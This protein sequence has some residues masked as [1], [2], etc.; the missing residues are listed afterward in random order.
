ML[1]SS[2][3]RYDG[4]LMEKS[5][6][7]C[8][9]SRQSSMLGILDIALYRMSNN[10]LSE[11]ATDEFTGWLIEQQ[12]NGLLASF[13][14]TQM[15]TVHAC[16][17]KLLESALRIGDANFLELLID[18]GIDNSPLK[19]VYGGRNL[20]RA[21]SRD[22]M[23]IV[24]IL[25]KNGADVNMPPRQYLDPA[26]QVATR[27][28]HAQIVQ[29]LLKAGANVNAVSTPSHCF[30]D[31]NT[32]LSEAADIEIIELVRILLT[33]GANIDIYTTRWRLSTIDNDELHQILVSA[34]SE[35]YSS[36]NCCAVL[37]AATTGTQ[38]LSKY[39]A[40][41]GKTDALVQG[42]LDEALERARDDEN[43]I[44]FCGFL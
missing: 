10:L 18:S 22:N 33:T 9:P 25:L 34:N 28:G 5:Q 11:E 44:F 13:L 1:V 26:L 30:F 39:L 2:L 19:G 15:P 38:A 27:H 43:E 40:E 36:I 12:Q 41:K 37:E 35:G 29:V 6:L 16:A 31:C 23:Q 3:E 24:Q 17:T 4:E 20:E 14:Q 21:A 32:A 42:V 8:G 7:L